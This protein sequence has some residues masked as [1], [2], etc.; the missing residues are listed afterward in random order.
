MEQRWTFRCKR[1]AQPVG[2]FVA[3]HGFSR[4]DTKGF[5]DLHK[6]RAY[7]PVVATRKGET[8]GR[9]GRLFMES[10]LAYLSSSSDARFDSLLA[11]S[12]Q[13]KNAGNPSDGQLGPLARV[14]SI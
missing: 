2:F 7:Q 5:G 4:L 14:K 6:V 13:P 8:L 10:L 11:P 12:L 3:M 9:G 1:P